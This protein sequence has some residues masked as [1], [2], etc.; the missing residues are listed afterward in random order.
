M[1]NVLLDTNVVIDVLA[2][3]YPFFP[4]AA[5]IFEL[6]ATGDIKI[7]LTANSLTDIFYLLQKL[8]GEAKTREN[9][10]KLLKLFQIL[11]V[12]GLDCKV[13]IKSE[14]PD[15]EDALI[16]ACAQRSKMDYIVSRDQHFLKNCDLTITPA[17]FL[18]KF[19]GN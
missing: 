16:E 14:N 13:A 1:M 11:P 7:Y 8:I 5:T 10:S 17:G 15:F 4:E 2:K 12:D 9:I 3:R 19:Y 6:D 18:E